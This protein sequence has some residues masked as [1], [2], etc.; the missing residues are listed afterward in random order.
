[1]R[2]RAW[3][4]KK[5]TVGLYVPLCPS[6]LLPTLPSTV[7][8]NVRSA[9]VV[10]TVAA[11]KHS[12]GD[13]SSQTR[14]IRHNVSKRVATIRFATVFRRHHSGDERVFGFV[15]GLAARQKIG[16]LLGVPMSKGLDRGARPVM[17]IEFHADAGELHV[18]RRRTELHER[19]HQTAAHIRRPKDI[20]FS[21]FASVHRRRTVSMVHACRSSEACRSARRINSWSSSRLPKPILSI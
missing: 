21:F 14:S 13:T 5:I 6:V 8:R 12:T 9:R 16:A 15:P 19:T 18:L 4:S 10:P 3:G 7:A 11:P 2:S 1:M 20:R 17:N